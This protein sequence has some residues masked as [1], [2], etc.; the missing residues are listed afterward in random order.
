[1]SKDSLRRGSVLADRIS[2]WVSW[3][4]ENYGE[5]HIYISDELI[6]DMARYLTILEDTDDGCTNG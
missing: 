2:Q 3:A 5:E 4:V 1:M 6:D